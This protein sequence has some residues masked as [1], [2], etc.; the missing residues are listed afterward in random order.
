[1][2]IYTYFFSL[3][4]NTSL[5][6]FF[7]T[8]TVVLSR[9]GNFPWRYFYPLTQP[10]VLLLLFFIFIIIIISSSSSSSRSGIKK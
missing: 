2:E 6:S 5:N 3:A 9:S 7:T 10:Q 8:E 4:N 1:M